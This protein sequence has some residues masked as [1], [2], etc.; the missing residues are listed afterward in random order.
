ME[1][2]FPK[3]KRSRHFHSIEEDF[4]EGTCKHPEAPETKL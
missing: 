1:P 2:D 3:K 4:R